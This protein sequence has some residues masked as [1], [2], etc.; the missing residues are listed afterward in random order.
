M[1]YDDRHTLVSR[2]IRGLLKARCEGRWNNTQ[3][4]AFVL[5]ALKNYYERCEAETPDFTVHAWMDE[6]QILEESFT[7]RSTAVKNSFLTMPQVSRNLTLQ[8]LGNGRLYYRMALRYLPLNLELPALECGLSVSRSYLAEKGCVQRIDEKQWQV[9]AGSLVKVV[10]KLKCRVRRYH[11]ALVDPL[12]GGF[13][14]VNPALA[15]SEDVP[16]TESPSPFWFRRHWFDHHD[17]RDD[18]V[19]VFAEEL[20][21]GE[22]EYIY[23]ARAVTAG[24]FL[25]PPFKAEEMY[26]PEIFGRNSTSWM[27]VE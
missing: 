14:V 25:V 15:V 20:A 11:I 21:A 23:Y 12:P 1:R 4:N 9:E 17:F 6:Q 27:R 13:E 3:E 26:S 18:R 2:V 19:E 22:Y 16:E 7:G 5:M 8:Q 10:L 24:S